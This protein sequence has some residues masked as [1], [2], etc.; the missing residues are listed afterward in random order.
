MNQYQQEQN[1]KW[2]VN[3]F[4]ERIA[5]GGIDLKFSE[6]VHICKGNLESAN[7]C[8]LM[9]LDRGLYINNINFDGGDYVISAKKSE[10]YQ[11]GI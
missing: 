10:Q 7:K 9:L 4:Y 3:H 1:T 11:F 6:L 5:Y 2:F 8:L